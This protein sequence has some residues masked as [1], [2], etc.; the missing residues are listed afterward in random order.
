MTI[1]SEFWNLP[2]W[3]MAKK[4]WWA[5]G[6]HKK[7]CPTDPEG[8]KAVFGTTIPHNSENQKKSHMD[9]MSGLPLKTA[10]AAGPIGIGETQ[11]IE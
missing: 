9:R 5:Y 6:A 4:V 11:R 1:F 2:F 7:N 8:Q 10:L 3:A